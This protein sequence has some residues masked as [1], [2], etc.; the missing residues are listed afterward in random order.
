M[1]SFCV[2]VGLAL[3]FVLSPRPDAPEVPHVCRALQP[4]HAEPLACLDGLKPTILTAELAGTGARWACQLQR[5]APVPTMSLALAE[6]AELRARGLRHEL[7]G[8]DQ[9]FFIPLYGALSLLLVA[10]LW[11][12]ARMY[13]APQPARARGMAVLLGVVSLALVLLDLY[14]ENRLMLELLRE[15]D[16]LGVAGAI[17]SR[18]ID[19]STLDPLA[20]T[21]RRASCVKWLACAL[22]AGCLAGAFRAVLRW[23]PAS[24]APRLWRVLVAAACLAA[25]VAS[26]LMG[27]GVVTGWVGDSL[28]TPVQLL[29]A[30][31]GLAMVSVL[32]AALAACW[33]AFK[34]G[35]RYKPGLRVVVPPRQGGKSA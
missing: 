3:L 14:G 13:E 1:F 10:W 9:L 8:Y 5:G 21:A 17:G 24:D 20:H 34:R 27:L 7:A 15:L 11:S 35:I 2:A 29:S 25:L 6:C 23:S 4:K 18:P 28:H 26:V 32:G 30:G 19:W 22:W 12:H 33:G 31:M 16:S